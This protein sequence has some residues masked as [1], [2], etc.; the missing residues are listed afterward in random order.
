MK[1]APL[2]KNESQRIEALNKLQLLDTDSELDFDDIVSLASKICD[3]PISLI[4]LVDSDRQW[5]K[6]RYGLSAQ[7]TQRD[8][9]FCAHAILQDEF[10]FIPDSREDERFYDNPL[11]IGDPKVIFYAGAVIKEPV[12]QLPIGT[13]CLIDS[14]PRTLSSQQKESLA[15]LRNQVQKLLELK[16][17]IARNK[18]YV[19][20]LHEQALRSEHIL[21]NALLGSWDWNLKTNQ[22]R[23]DRRWSEML[24]LKPEETRQE[25]STWDNRVHPDDKAKAY[26]DIQN[27]LEGKTPIYENIHRAR[28]ENGEWV[29]I[30][31]RGKVY[32]RDEAGRPLKFSGVHLNITKYKEQ[33]FLS[34]EIQ[35]MGNIGGWELDVKTLLTNWTEQTYK[36]HALSPSIPSNKIMAIQYYAPHERDRIS[37]LVSDCMKGQ[38]YRDVFEF[39]DALG[40]K[41]WV[42][43][44]GEPIFSSNGEVV[45]LRG[46]FQDVTVKVESQKIIEKNQMIATQMAKMRSLGEMSAGIAHEIN[47]PLAVISGTAEILRNKY[48][49]SDKLIDR[50]SKSVN[51]IQN[52]VNGLKKFSRSEPTSNKSLVSLKEI[53]EDILNIIGIRAKHEHVLL[54]SNLNTEGF[55]YCNSTEIEQVVINIINNAIDSVSGS[56]DP[57]VKIELFEIG[58][59]VVMQVVDSG[60]GINKEIVHKL[61]DPFFTTKPVDKGMG[62]GLSISKGI[63]DGH[64][65]SI[66]VNTSLSNTC[67]EIRFKKPQES[68]CVS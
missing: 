65:G 59:D 28:H 11:V 54:S 18:Q 46:T 27:Y 14:K 2:H 56:P 16:T 45:R 7:Q 12:S 43:A 41:K 32:E 1:S 21:D 50:V 38:S 48:K 34:Q 31:D 19:L 30:L 23:F 61:F 20:E 5:F 9:A 47:N 62:L 64:G 25:L 29:W 6:A 49:E 39:I 33:E 40:V 22:V 15:Q 66:F 52:I 3:V 26:L 42:E 24:G 60:L 4:S 36:I 58:E 53:T 57:W 51:R 67:F 55:I 35:K 44:A 17:Q 68:S 37:Q 10:F 63:V 13:L 8:V